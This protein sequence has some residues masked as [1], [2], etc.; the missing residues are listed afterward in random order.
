MYL[1]RFFVVFLI[2]TLF[3]SVSP[4]QADIH[5]LNNEGTW[6][7][8]YFS[9]TLI[10]FEVGPNDAS[11]A[12]TYA[13]QGVTFND[14]NT[15]H[16]KFWGATAYAGNYGM[17]TKPNAVDGGG[18]F[19]A[20]FSSPVKAIS[21]HSHDVEYP[22]F[23]NSI[24]SFYDSSNNLINS[25]NLGGTGVGH[26]GTVWGFNGFFSD[27]VDIA[28]VDLAIDAGDAMSFDNFRFAS[29][30]VPEPSAATVGLLFGLFGVAGFRV[31]RKTR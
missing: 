7:S 25:F 11:V 19:S 15:G 3:Q 14:H 30:S 6:L 12:G 23:P 26:G 16:P 9:N 10:D 18:G 28:R 13:G 21:L 24:L 8:Q 1:D 5:V 17:F 27:A 22:A 2:A 29:A 31:G 4:L 20:V